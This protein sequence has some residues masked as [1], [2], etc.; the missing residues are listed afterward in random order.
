MENALNRMWS[1]SGAGILALSLLALWSWPKLFGVDTHPIFGWAEAQT[2]AAWF[3]PGLRYAIGVVAA[4][5]AVLVL[6]P[7]TR[8]IA[9]WSALALSL[10]F[11]LAHLSPML[12]VNI[13]A[14]TPLMEALAAGRTA[15]EIAAM[16]LKTDKG[17]HFTL[18]M[19]NLGLAAITIAAEYAH[20]KPKPRSL[21]ET[22]AAQA[23]PVPA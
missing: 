23:A 22:L 16:G 9:A 20:R 4:V 11:I 8:L 21:R 18:A 14:Y 19:I 5:I 6:V 17:A 2:G 3:E 12:G 1:V 15:E 7:R 13:P 10:A